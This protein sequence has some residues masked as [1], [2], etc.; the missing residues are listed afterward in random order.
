MKNLAILRVLILGIFALLASTMLPYV[1]ADAGETLLSL[2]GDPWDYIVGTRTY[3][4]TPSDGTFS[5]QRP[6]PYV[7][8]VFFTSFSQPNWSVR[9]VGPDHQNLAAGIYPRAQ[10][11]SPQV[12]E[13]G[14]DLSGDGR[15]CSSTGKFQIKQITYD[16][17]NNVS[18]L[19]ARFEQ[20][21]ENFGPAAYGEIRFN[22]DSSVAVSAPL[23]ISLQRDDELTFQVSASGSNPLTLA[24][25]NLPDGAS[26][27][28][29]GDGT[30]TFT[31]TPGY[32]QQ[33]D[34]VLNFLASDNAG[35]QDSSAT[36][37]RV[38]GVSSFFIN[39]DAG[40]WISRGEPLW[41]TSRD[42]YILSQSNFDNG[43]TITLMTPDL[44]HDWRLNFVA[45]GNQT[46][47][48]GVYEGA[49]RFPFQDSTVP[50]LDVS[51]DSHGCNTLAG[52]FE[53]KEIAY[54]PYGELASFW[55]TYEQ[56]CEGGVPAAYGEIL[57]NAN[58]R[59]LNVTTG[60]AGSGNAAIDTSQFPCPS[61]TCPQAYA[62]GSTA[63]LR[64]A[65]NF[66]SVLDAWDGDPDCSD[67]QVTLDTDI[68]CI[69]VFALR[70]HTVSVSKTGS[71]GGT[72]SSSPAGLSCGQ[73][74]SQAF[75]HGTTVTLT[76]TPDAGSIF[77]GWTGG[78]CSGTGSCTLTVSGDVNV[79]A[80]FSPGFQIHV[81]KTGAGIGTVTS[82]PA[83]IDCGQSCLADFVTGTSV[84]FTAAPASFSAF[85]GWSG[86]GCSGTDPCVVTVDAAIDIT[87]NFET[88]GNLFIQIG[89]TGTGTVK[90]STGTDCTTDCSQTLL[91]GT[92]VTL[93][94]VPS[95]GSVFL[96]WSGDACSGATPSCSFIFTG[97]YVAAYFG[98]PF[99]ISVSKTGS[100][101]GTV[102]SLPAGI[103]CGSACSMTLNA[104]RPVSVTALA[105][106]DSVFMGWS[107]GVCSGTDYC[108]FDAN[109]DTTI[110]AT[111]ALK[112]F[113]VNVT[114]LGPGTGL[115][116]SSTAGIDCGQ[117]CSGSATIGSTITLTA[118]PSADSSFLTWGGGCG[119]ATTCT[120]TLDANTS[121]SA[122]F[123]RKTFRLQV[124]A[125][126]AVVTTPGIVTSSPAGINCGQDC[127]E[128]VQ[129]GTVFT[130]I[131]S[132]P[133]D[134]AFQGWSGGSCSGTG[135]CTVTVNADTT[136]LATFNYKMVTLN[137]AK[138]GNGSGVVWSPSI[139]LNCGTTCSETTIY[140]RSVTLSASPSSNSIFTGW[141]GGGCTGT[142][143]C[144]I[145]LRADTSVT[146]NFAVKQFTLSVANAGSGSGT[147]TSSPVGID[148]GT[149]CSE[150]LTIGTQVALSATP[151]PDSF[152][153]GWSGGCSGTGACTVTM[154]SDTAVTANFTK[155]LLLSSPNG[156][157]IW[158]KG[159]TQP[160]TWTSVGLAG[161]IKVDYS[162]DG[163]TTW[164]NIISPT[165]NDG[166][167]KWKVNKTPTNQA[168]LRVCTT[169][170]PIICDASD[171]NF[172][173]Q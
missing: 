39:G 114:K 110:T 8:N 7:V 91:T 66:G 46:L 101:S 111:F 95:A 69:A 63:G 97:Q 3:F 15:G 1:S 56:H 98:I 2:T 160:I 40:D 118:T 94:A 156:G 172:T 53:V 89:G 84:T 90:R 144:T 58:A 44:S 141:S 18:S 48:V 109:T 80:A 122:F 164:T 92:A 168:R 70:T 116:S 83:G 104:P 78:T 75:D 148:C 4:L 47:T 135:T 106:S 17:N 150:I 151:S 161:K 72:I 165:G 130:L 166:T 81:S 128:I 12:G 132:A 145:V 86:G 120:F 119:T 10:S 52:R 43:V 49:E 155:R 146:A 51:G 71:G 55:A 153:A 23:S 34:Y 124:A 67:A 36:L 59:M 32:D 82:S 50:G 100:G 138:A 45:P 77:S 99:T 38:T 103:N 157:E 108:L 42:S 117:T 93:N 62:A 73:T 107:G 149:D 163:G 137:V 74:C 126:G 29:H 129:A 16:A 85:T 139:F 125:M 11:D 142:A 35:K 19:W 31:W 68:S 21:C 154:N 9:F 158:K 28:D 121:I 167:Q 61:Y 65:P 136:V 33:G 170:A 20:R 105:A 88:T 26:F 27:I 14:F 22:V 37:I 169:T 6:V 60:G 113:N 162:G 25:T 140:G 147:V 64:A 171:G 13:A 127:Q 79:T 134:L 131:A 96:G 123:D 87:A 30:G 5:I 41:L 76:A 54:G 57:F 173:I 152:F 24:G 112:T 133:D 115:I 102:T 143:D 159:T